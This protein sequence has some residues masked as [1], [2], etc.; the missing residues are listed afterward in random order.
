MPTWAGLL[1][2]TVLW[3]LVVFVLWAFVVFGGLV[4]LV[5][6]W[7]AKGIDPRLASSRFGLR[8]ART[9]LPG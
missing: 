1:L 7:R 9:A 5:R 4:F 2:V 3:G 8:G 6:V